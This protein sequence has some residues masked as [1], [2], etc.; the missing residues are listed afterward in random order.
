MRR[1]DT[2]PP[3]EI[4]EDLTSRTDVKRANRAVE[5]TLA[6]LSLALF[7]LAPRRLAALELPESVYETVMDA[8]VMKNARARVRQLGLVRV[9]LRGADWAAIQEKV[10]YVAEGRE[11]PPPAE[12]GE[13][14][15][16]GA[17]ATWVAR[18]LGEGFA[19]VDAFLVD[20][21]R[22][23]RARLLD[24]L[25][26]VYRGT[27]EQRAKAERKLADV[28]QNILASGRR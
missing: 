21:P 27:G 8:R 22:T 9:A 26:R 7:E 15:V 10:R 1:R 16:A 14:P 20:Y 3:Q 11:P 2:D 13:G 23:D 12:N 6:R 28:V 18:L 24:L 25:R 4:A 5:E 17:G 19:G